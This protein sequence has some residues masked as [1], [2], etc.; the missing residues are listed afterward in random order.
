[1]PE[2]HFQEQEAKEVDLQNPGKSRGARDKEAYPEG[3]EM[4]ESS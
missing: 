2:R 3:A 4:S 1:L